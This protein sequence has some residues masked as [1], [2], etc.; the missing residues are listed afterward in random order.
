MASFFAEQISYLIITSSADM[1]NRFG[2]GLVLES[3]VLLH[4][5]QIFTRLIA[6]CDFR[7]RKKNLVFRRKRLQLPKL[8]SKY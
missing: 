6:C 7:K 1:I 2:S 8:K 3:G 5:G 4:R